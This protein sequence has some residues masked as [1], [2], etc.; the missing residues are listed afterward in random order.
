M[1]QKQRQQLKRQAFVISITKWV[2]NCS[3]YKGR[4]GRVK[5][6]KESAQKMVKKML[7]VSR[8]SGALFPSIYM[9]ATGYNASTRQRRV[10]AIV[11]L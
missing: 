4:G 2:M 6:R 1:G 10:H 7:P 5:N 11:E 9:S 3:H 8:A